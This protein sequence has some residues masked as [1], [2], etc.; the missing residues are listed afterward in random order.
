[1]LTVQFHDDDRWPFWLGVFLQILAFAALTWL[2]HFAAGWYGVFLC[3]LLGMIPFGLDRAYLVNIRQGATIDSAH[4]P[5][6]FFMLWSWF[7]HFCILLLL[8]L[9]VLPR[10]PWRRHP[11]T[12]A[13]VLAALIPI[14]VLLEIGAY[15]RM[16]SGRASWLW[17]GSSLLFVPLLLSMVALS[18]AAGEWT[19][20]FDM[21]AGRRD[22]REKTD[23]RATVV[24]ERRARPEPVRLAVALSGGGYRAAVIHAGVL[25]ELDRRHIRIRYLST[26]SGG[27][28][29][30]AY[31]ALGYRPGDFIHNLRE[32]KPGLPFEKL[33]VF[34]SLSSWLLPWKSDADVYA[35]HFARA[36][37]GS[38][39]LANLPDEPTL[40]VN[41]TDLEVKS[42]SAREV[43]FKER[44]LA[45]PPDGR[46]AKAIRVADSVAASG[47]FPF[48]FEA[49]PIPWFPSWSEDASAN[50]VNR[51]FVDGGVLENL[52]V[53]GLRR[54]LRLGRHLGQ[55]PRKPHVLLISDASHPGDPE[56]LAAKPE[57][58]SL[59]Q[60]ILEISY[61]ELQRRLLSQYTGHPDYWRWMGGLKPAAQV[62]SVPYASLDAD[63]EADDPRTLW[64]VVIPATAPQLNS[65][66]QPYRDSNLH[67]QS[68]ADVQTAVSKLAT[69]R[70]LE[71]GEV[72]QGAWL[73]ATLVS[74]YWPAIDC[75]FRKAAQ[76]DAT[77]PTDNPPPKD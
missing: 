2:A 65:M 71:P 9:N 64:V 58:A 53:E 7:S 21:L 70:E 4:D 60:H 22:W 52:G 55:K 12:G 68:L 18:T 75:A 34:H 56:P 50:P 17:F 29:L 62:S 23:Y 19:S 33:S 45:A 20:G 66:L 44:A 57:L 28:I 26:V 37:F 46:L 36:F 10:I 41:V 24:A 51:R 73:G 40:I 49:K 35:D 48:A 63:L 15:R 3:V 77:C 47:A 25:S 30:G 43:L 8:V 1:M 38:S 39:T 69:L 11:G 16:Q 31:Y 13:L 74:V 67:G 61:G 42:E 76:A 6:R 14:L 5:G 59:A 27:S 32:H 54:Y 72:E